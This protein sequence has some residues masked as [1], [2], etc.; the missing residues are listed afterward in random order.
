MNQDKVNAILDAYKAWDAADVDA[1][2]Y[3]QSHPISQRAYKR[4]TELKDAIER[5]SF[6]E[7]SEAGI[8]NNKIH[9]FLLGHDL[10]KDAEKFMREEFEANAL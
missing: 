9:E 6:S 8:Q 5:A 2:G 3:S 7:R 4:L 10:Y 1:I